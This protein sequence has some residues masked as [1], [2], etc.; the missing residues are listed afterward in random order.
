MGG[1]NSKR[2]RLP[3]K[4]VDENQ[5]RDVVQS[6]GYFVATDLQFKLVLRHASWPGSL[7]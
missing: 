7:S 1:G 4:T 3:R 2:K 5:D 6:L